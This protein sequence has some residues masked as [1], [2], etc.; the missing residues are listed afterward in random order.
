MEDATLVYTAHKNI[1]LNVNKKIV[2]SYKEEER[3]KD[4]FVKT[5]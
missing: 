1:R 2:L 5:H 3:E 4:L